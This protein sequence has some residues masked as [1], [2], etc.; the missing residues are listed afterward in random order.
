MLG[1]FTAQFVA[2]WTAP[3]DWAG[4]VRL[5]VAGV[6]LALG[7]ALL[8]ARSH[9]LTRVMRTGL[10]PPRALDGHSSSQPEGSTG[11]GRHR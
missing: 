1:L 6:Y 7:A 11:T 9:H 8:A 2:A 3:A 5:T 10:W 4:T